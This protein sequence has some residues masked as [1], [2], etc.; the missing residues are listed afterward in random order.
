MNG[1]EGLSL[2]AVARAVGVTPPALY[3]YFDGRKGLALAV[4]EDVTAERVAVVSGAVD[5]A[6]REDLGACLYAATRAFFDWSIA[7]PAEFDLLMGAGYA[8]PASFVEAFEPVF[9]RELGRLYVSLFTELLNRTGLEYPEDDRLDPSLARN[10]TAYRQLMGAAE[11]FPLGVVLT[12]IT[13]WR[14]IY[15]LTCMA[16]YGHMATAFDDFIALFD[17]MLDDLLAGLGLLR[18]PGQG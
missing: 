3:R 16:V 11:D 2:S 17:H 6:G 15:G 1:V 9:V 12:M 4:C 7:H 10:L 18:G 14:Q 8:R 13:C 5:R